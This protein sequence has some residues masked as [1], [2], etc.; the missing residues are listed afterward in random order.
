MLI[1]VY[2]KEKN[3][4]TSSLL[5][6]ILKSYYNINIFE[7]WENFDIYL[8]SFSFLSLHKMETYNFSTFFQWHELRKN[9]G[10]KGEKYK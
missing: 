5:C 8:F 7:I 3:I 9:A 4:K 6:T 1:L 10:F 2:F